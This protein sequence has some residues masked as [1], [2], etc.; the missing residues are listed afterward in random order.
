MGDLRADLLEG[1]GLY[2]QFAF[3]VGRLIIDHGRLLPSRH[4]HV[5]PDL[6]SRLQ[7]RPLD[8]KPGDAWEEAE[9]V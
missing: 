6:T 9:C 5:L 7:S 2:L 4:S 3:N 8:V 1:V